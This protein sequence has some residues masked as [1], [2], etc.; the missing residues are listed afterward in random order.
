MNKLSPDATFW[1]YGKK[2][3]VIV[4][5]GL[6]FGLKIIDSLVHEGG[7]LSSSWKWS[8]ICGLGGMVY[9]SVE[10]AYRRGVIDQAGKADDVRTTSD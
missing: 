6:L 9:S 10:Y 7:V 4:F 1:N 8:L 5:I 3:G 2:L